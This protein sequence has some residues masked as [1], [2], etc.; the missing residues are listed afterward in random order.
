[1]RC[2]DF[3]ENAQLQINVVKATGN[4]WIEIHNPTDR[5]L[6]AKGLYL[7]D[8]DN[9]HQKWALPSIIVRPGETVRVLARNNEVDPA[10]KRAR[11]NF[12]I[13][14]GERLRL[15]DS[16]GEVLSLVEVTLMKRDEVQQRQRDGK[17]AILEA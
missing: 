12:N 1:M 17:F 6:S 15:V 13:S 8:S 16:E 10:L 2:P 14:F 9:N 11:T 4:G 5:T 3:N 7:S